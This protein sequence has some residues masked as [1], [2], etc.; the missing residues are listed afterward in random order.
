LEPEVTQELD[1]LKISLNDEM[2]QSL[3]LE[4]EELKD[5]N[6]DISSNFIITASDSFGQITSLT[7]SLYI[8]Y[9]AN[10]EFE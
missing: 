9:E 8:M 7:G 6:K 10:P 3:F 1:T 2:I 5:L 4:P